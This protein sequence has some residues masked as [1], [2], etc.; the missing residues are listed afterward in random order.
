MKKLL[1]ILTLAIST[2][3]AFAQSAENVPTPIV[4]DGLVAYLPFNGNGND[5]SGNGNNVDVSSLSF[6]TDRYK[7]EE[8]SLR[9]AGD[10]VDT[11]ISDKGTISFWLRLDD[12]AMMGILSAGEPSSINGNFELGTYTKESLLGEYLSKNKMFSYVVNTEG[13]V[14]YS[15]KETKESYP[16]IVISNSAIF[17]GKWHQVAIGYNGDTKLAIWLDGKP[18]SGSLFAW[19]DGLKNTSNVSEIKKS[20][21]V[22]PEAPTPGASSLLLGAVRNEK[23]GFIKKFSKLNGAMDELRVYS[24]LLKDNEIQVLYNQERPK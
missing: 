3:I 15:C 13:L 11:G 4:T 6:D 14:F 19:G 23:P 16:S 7:K 2:T 8:M 17:D 22:L 20:P 18:A 1:M 10:A 5:V 24:R 21:F 9:L 12:K